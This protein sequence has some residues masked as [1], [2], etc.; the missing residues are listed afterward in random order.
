VIG[1]MGLRIVQLPAPARRTSLIVLGGLIVLLVA[2]NLAVQ[3]PGLNGALTLTYRNSCQVVKQAGVALHLMPPSCT[4]KGI[5]PFAWLALTPYLFG[6]LA[7]AFAAAVTCTAYRAVAESD[8][9]AELDARAAIVDQA[10]RCTAL[11]LVTSAL[12]MKLFYDLPLSLIPEDT[13]PLT[14]M[15]GYAQGMALFWGTVF[16]LTLIA[17]FGPGYAILKRQLQTRNIEAEL[18]EVLTGKNVQK[19]AVT[20]LTMLAPL[21]VGASGSLLEQLAGAL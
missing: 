19:Y 14:L 6:L 1:L 11:V 9:Q 5:S 16:T 20:A 8:V 2:A 21:L 15:Q 17:I 10:F 18:P 7:A 13:T 3:V 4:G 12:T